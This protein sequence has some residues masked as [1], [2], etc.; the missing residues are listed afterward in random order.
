MYWWIYITHLSNPQNCTTQRM[1]CN[2]KTQNNL[3]GAQAVLTDDLIGK[4]LCENNQN[5]EE[6]I[7]L[8]F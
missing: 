3:S 5:I 2:E 1:N 6:S 7:D 4:E 8:F